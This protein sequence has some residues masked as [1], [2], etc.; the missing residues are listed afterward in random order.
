MKLLFLIL[1][2]T[3]FASEPLNQLRTLDGPRD[4]ESVNTNFRNQ[5]NNL[6]RQDEKI[7][8]LEDST[9]DAT[10]AGNNTFTGN[11]TYEGTETFSGSAIFN[12]TVE[13]ASDVEVSSSIVLGNVGQTLVGGLDVYAQSIDG[14][15]QSSGCYIIMGTTGGGLDDDLTFTSTTTENNVGPAGVLMEA[16]GRIPSHL[17]GK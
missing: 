10:L 13:F 17:C 2:S 4:T 14:V 1:T 12:D 11:N 9:S 7:I 16:D 3:V 8:D 6:R 5:A 15:T